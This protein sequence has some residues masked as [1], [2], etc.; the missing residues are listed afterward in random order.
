MDTVKKKKCK[1]HVI[2]IIGLLER[3]KINDLISDLN[4]MV[5][6][7]ETQADNLIFEVDSAIGTQSQIIDHNCL[8]E[9][10]NSLSKISS[11]V[12]D[13]S[14]NSVKNTL[15]S[16]ESKIQ[17]LENEIRSKNIEKFNE[18]YEDDVARNKFIDELKSL[19]TSAAIMFNGDSLRQQILDLFV[20]QDSDI[21]SDEKDK[22]I[23]M[24]ITY[25]DLAVKKYDK[26]I[27][28]IQKMI[29]IIEE[30]K[31]M[32]LSCEIARELLF[33]YGKDALVVRTP[34]ELDSMI[35]LKLEGVEI[36]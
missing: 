17:Q 14:I 12:S 1:N 34:N 21:L 7:L 35:E 24:A 13:V 25:L 5:S 26:Y 19:N 8:M 36:L 30:I 32:K 27:A 23:S 33:S 28:K 20:V 3:E 10:E 18:I 29:D 4:E 2:S 11:S 31:L 15:N 9:I 6:A 16:M 22:M